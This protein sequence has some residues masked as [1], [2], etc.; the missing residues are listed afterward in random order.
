M[1]KSLRWVKILLVFSSTASQAESNG[2]DEFK[3][4]LVLEGKPPSAPGSRI[5]IFKNKNEGDGGDSK[6]VS[7]SPPAVSP[8]WLRRGDGA[9]AHVYPEIL[10]VMMLAGV[11]FILHMSRC[12]RRF[13]EPGSLGQSWDPNNWHRFIARLASSNSS[14]IRG[15]QS[16]I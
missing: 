14:A 2:M 12:S 16:V 9:Y 6:G 5:D 1:L 13:N 11:G 10:S 3:G 4:L 8:G 15:K 7:S